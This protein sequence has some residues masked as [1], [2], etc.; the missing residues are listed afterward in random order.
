MNNVEYLAVT[1]PLYMNSDIKTA[2]RRT[3]SDIWHNTYICPLTW[4]RLTFM[5]SNFG[6]H[7]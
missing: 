5:L 3:T 1:E 6:E 7:K 4:S 2:E